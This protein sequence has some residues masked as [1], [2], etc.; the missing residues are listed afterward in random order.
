CEA[1]LRAAWS[2]LASLRPA[3][4]VVM[5]LLVRRDRA[6]IRAYKGLQA[7]GARMTFG[8]E[9]GAPP[10]SGA[11]R[12]VIGI[13]DGDQV[14]SGRIHVEGDVF[15]PP[16]VTL[17]IEPGAEIVFRADSQW[18]CVK[19]CNVG[20]EWP[21]EL[22]G[23]CRLLVGGRL[24]AEG[25]AQAP[26]SWG[27]EAWAGIHFVTDSWGSSLSGV[28]ISKTLCAAVTLTDSTQLAMSSSRLTD[29]ESGV[30]VL[31]RDASVA[32]VDCRIERCRRRGLSCEGGALSARR[33]LVSDCGE[34]G[35]LA[36]QAE[37]EFEECTLSGSPVG[38]SLNGGSARL[39]G[40]KVSGASKAAFEFDGGA[41]ELRGSSVEDCGEAIRFGGGSLSLVDFEAGGCGSG[42]SQRA[43][44]LSWSGGKISGGRF[45]LESAGLRIRLEAVLFQDQSIAACRVEGG[46][47]TLRGVR[48]ERAA[49]G[50]AAA[51]PVDAEDFGLEGCARGVELS[52]G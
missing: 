20:K 22:E 23:K 46:A 35:V 11:A 8:G 6:M 30:A 38:L 5:A 33:V 48:V 10:E 4:G 50:L 47:L 36:E 21:Q 29:C 41:Y 39:A 7:L 45:G 18:D 12:R 44:E 27:G 51:G 24:I 43:G 16:G 34:I 49:L 28:I 17:R 52:A 13:L 2:S 26:I 1:V 19:E 9:I 32:L 25:T 37:L 31:G 15:V 42:V 3:R 40:L 14:W